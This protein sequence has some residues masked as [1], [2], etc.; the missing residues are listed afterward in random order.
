[1]DPLSDVLR[2]VRLKT[3]LLLPR[4]AAAPWSVATVAARDSRAA[5]ASRDA[6]LHLVSHPRVREL[7]G[8]ARRNVPGAHATR[9][10]HR[11]SARRCSHH[12]ERRGASSPTAN[13]L[14]RSA[15]PKPSIIGR[16]ARTIPPFVC[17]FLGCD[18]SPFNPLLASL[19]RCMHVSGIA[20]GWL[21][22]FPRQAV[23][24]SRTGPRRERDDAHPHG[25]AHVHRGRSALCGQLPPQQTGW[26]GGLKDPVVGPA[27]VAAARS[28]AYPWTLAELARAIASSRTVLAERF[29]QLVGVSPMQY[30]TRWRLQ[31]AVGT[32]RGRPRP[33]SRR[34]ARRWATSRRRRSAARS[35]EIPGCPLPRG[36]GRAGGN[37][38]PTEVRSPVSYSTPREPQQGQSRSPARPSDPRRIRRGES[39]RRRR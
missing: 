4:K 36:G 32:A 28:P 26:L 6:A 10:R 3:A 16:P 5:Y 17:G 38:S 19:P 30:L 1:M 29:S 27:L 25:R 8:R 9:R 33:K 34:S 35:R 12:V 2:A 15:I 14:G 21:S 39:V 20:T 24:E 11:V 13:Q 22:Q 18:V 31:L 23:A 37:R 7:L